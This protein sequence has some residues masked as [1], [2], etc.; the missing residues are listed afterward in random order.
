[1]SLK[2]TPSR[3]PPPDDQGEFT[4]VIR[5]FRY[6]CPLNQACFISERVREMRRK[7]V[8]LEQLVLNLDIE[9]LDDFRKLMSFQEIAVTVANIPFLAACARELKYKELS[10]FLA[11]ARPESQPVTKDNVRSQ[12]RWKRALQLNV[13]PE[14]EFIASHFYKLESEFLS[15]LDP[16]ALEL[17]VTNGKFLCRDEDQLFTIIKGLGAQYFSLYRYVRFF[18][19]APQNFAELTRRI[20]PSL[21]D[22]AVWTEAHAQRSWIVANSARY[23]LAFNGEHGPFS[24]I[25]SFLRDVGGGNPHERGLVEITATSILPQCGQCFQLVDYGWEGYWR[26]QPE[27][28]THVQ[29]DFKSRRVN[30]RRYSIKG[31]NG[32]SI[33]AN[34]AL[35]GSKNGQEWTLLDERHTQDLVGTFVTKTYECN[36]HVDDFFRFIRITRIGPNSDGSHHFHLTSLEFF[37]WLRKVSE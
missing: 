37:G 15:G 36:Q 16:A 11:R 29:F 35:S 14:I 24:G 20:P 21:V 10:D 4:F 33:L 22:P 8:Y 12:L 18:V 25:M 9:H 17:V 2:F 32:P 26:S 3:G 28:S 30:I 1:M 27:E 19:L 23:C 6:T 5:G 31:H 7:D 13:D 34:W